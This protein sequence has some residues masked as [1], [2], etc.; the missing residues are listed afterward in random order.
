M[1]SP[2]AWHT[3]PTGK[4]DHRWW[5][6]TKWTEH[7]ADAGESKIDHLAP[8]DTPPA[9]GGDV[10][11]TD[12]VA[13]DTSAGAATGDAPGD[14]ATDTDQGSGGLSEAWEG[15]ADPQPTQPGWQQPGG[16]GHDATAQQPAWQQG[17]Q[18]GQGGDPYAQQPAWDN[19]AA[20]VQTTGGTDGVA[21]AALVIG[22]LSLLTS[23]FVIGG[24]GGVI[25]LVLGLVALGRIKRNR[26][27][28]RG[29]AITGVVTGALAIIVAIVV[30]I[31]GVSFF[32]D[33]A[34]EYEEC[35]QTN[36]REVC[37]QQLEEGILDRFGR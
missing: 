1:S 25:A 17:Q 31:I 12:T 9:P 20:Y 14:G 26:S 21:V 13:M 30:V 2:A 7:V 19:N 29:M 35:L 16:P 8:G 5:D 37:D 24:L 10:A 27:G 28:G 34:A 15:T 23:W 11:T 18:Y 6:G 36:S 22:I 4:H 3:D 33:A 32:G